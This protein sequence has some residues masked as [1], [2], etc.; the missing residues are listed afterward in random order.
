MAHII[1]LLENAG[2]L[3]DGK[4]NL[5]QV[6]SA[7][8]TQLLD[9]ANEAFDITAHTTVHSTPSL[10]S[11]TASLGLGGDRMPCSSLEC[12]LAKAKQLS[13]FAALYSD[14]VYIR[15][16]LY[17]IV[18]FARD[19]IDIA[20]LRRDFADDLRVLSY[21]LPLIRAGLVDLVSFS[22]CPHCLSIRALERVAPREYE[23]ACK[24]LVSRYNR[25]VIYRLEMHESRL[26]ILAKG[27]EVLIP[28]GVGINIPFKA[29]SLLTGLPPHIA[30]KVKAGETTLLTQEQAKRIKAGKGFS[31]EV[32]HS[33]AFELGGAHFLRTAYLSDRQLEVDFIRNLSQDPAARRR[34]ALMQK[35]MN[36]LVPFI[37]AVN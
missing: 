34:D 5:N 25:E 33:V 9:V 11:H 18:G 37:G 6:R 15:N 23:K 14:K 32:L 7:K 27:P 21:L 29:D 20:E 8:F 4:P 36:C 30:Q 19:S 10:F 17:D 12:R 26:A 3:I 28:H 13:Q 35:Y 22:F 1:D 31:D 24:R 2:L 16:F